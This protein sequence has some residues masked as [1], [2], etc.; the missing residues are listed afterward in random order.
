M[1][2][3]AIGGSQGRGIRWVPHEQMGSVGVQLGRPIAR[4]RASRGTDR[5]Q[6]PPFLKARLANSLRRLCAGIIFNAIYISSSSINAVQRR[7]G[8]ASRRHTDS[9]RRARARPQGAGARAMQSAGRLQGLP[10]GVVREQMGSGFGRRSSATAMAHFAAR[11]LVSKLG[12]LRLLA[13]NCA[14]A[15]QRQR[16]T[17]SGST[18]FAKAVTRR[19][20]LLR[21]LSSHRPTAKPAI[22]KLR[23]P[24]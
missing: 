23:A 10:W 6:A 21:A 19:G 4:R 1:A 16:S 3:C 2:R 13:A 22:R 8:A 18:E 17:R 11:R 7:H 5:C 12:R 15:I 14:T 24:I 20:C 9:S